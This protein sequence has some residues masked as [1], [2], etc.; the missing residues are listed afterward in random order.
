[1]TQVAEFSDRLKELLSDN[2]DINMADL[3]KR[4]NT[5][6]QSI[7]RYA[8]GERSPKHIVMLEIANVFGVSPAWLAGFD[9]PKYD[10]EGKYGKLPQTEEDKNAQPAIVSVRISSDDDEFTSQEKELI[11]KYRSLSLEEQSQ[12]L[13]ILYGKK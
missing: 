7:G 6:K 2:S 13:A 8:R 9:V 3:A 1:M 12:V 4:V 10:I 11:K 5:T